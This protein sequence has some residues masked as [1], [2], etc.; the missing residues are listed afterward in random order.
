MPVRFVLLQGHWLKLLNYGITEEGYQNNLKLASK[1]FRTSVMTCE[2]DEEYIKNYNTTKIEITNEINAIDP[3]KNFNK[4]L[5]I[6]IK[7]YQICKQ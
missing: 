5:Q 1:Y 4:K 7:E 2:G 6:I 3:V